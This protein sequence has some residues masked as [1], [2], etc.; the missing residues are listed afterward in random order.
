M[1]YTVHSLGSEGQKTPQIY[2]PRSK[3]QALWMVV[4]KEMETE[5]E[6]RSQE[7]DKQVRSCPKSS[8][9]KR[10]ANIGQP[11]FIWISLHRQGS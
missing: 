4:D 3:A 11:I 9:A 8:Q 5:A 7:L 2:L 6:R 1:A 10:L